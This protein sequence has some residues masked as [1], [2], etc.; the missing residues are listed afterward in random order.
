MTLQAGL[1]RLAAALG[2]EIRLRF[3]EPHRRQRL[4][5]FVTR[6]PHCLERLMA[7][8]QR[9]RIEGGRA[10]AWW[11]PTAPI[12]NRW[13]ASTG[14]PSCVVPWNERARRRSAALEML[15][16]APRSISWCWRGS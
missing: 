9:R 5:I 13:P 7:A 6:E 12:S 10:G 16:R 4:A 3:T 15:E 1:D 14:C 8:F 11:S 2:M